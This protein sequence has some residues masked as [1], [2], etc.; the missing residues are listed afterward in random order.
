MQFVYFATEIFLILRKMPDRKF[1]PFIL[2]IKRSLQRKD[3]WY[4]P[5]M[6]RLLVW[7]FRGSPQNSE[8]IVR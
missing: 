1:F 8:K 3:E 6:L 4:W 7:I 5:C 2:M